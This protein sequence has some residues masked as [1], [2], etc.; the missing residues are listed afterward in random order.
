[1]KR[2]ILIPLVLLFAVAVVSAGGVPTGFGTDDKLSAGLSPYGN[3]ELLWGEHSPLIFS[4]QDTLDAVTYTRWMQIGWAQ[5]GS[6]ASNA[7][8]QKYYPRNWTFTF[9]L[10]A[11]PVGAAVSEDSVGSGTISFA[12]AMDTVG[13]AL[14][15]TIGGT[16][17]LDSTQIFIKDGNYTHPLYGQWMF[18]D[19]AAAV[20]GGM[21][22][23]TNW[24]CPIRVLFPGFIRFTFTPPPAAIIDSCIIRWWLIGSY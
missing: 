6:A 16:F 5:D 4:G 9:N 21:A 20:E 15:D 18:E 2:F 7:V 1:M 11:Y 10:D 12:V 14:L 8:V 13:V 17:N 22:D 23:T 24:A 19:I 3:N